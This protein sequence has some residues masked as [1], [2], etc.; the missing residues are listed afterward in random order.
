MLISGGAYTHHS[1]QHAAALGHT[2]AAAGHLQPP[3]VSLVLIT[4]VMTVSVTRFGWSPFYSP[5]VVTPGTYSSYYHAPSRY[6]VLR[7]A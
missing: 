1:S 6:S 2:G 7:P 3:A 4:R 5:S